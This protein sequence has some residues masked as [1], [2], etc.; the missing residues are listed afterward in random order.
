VTVPD[1]LW[2]SLARLGLALLV[3]ALV[4]LE[5]EDAGKPAGL[6]TLAA[7]SFGSCLF[8]LLAVDLISDWSGFANLR[9]DPIRIV[10]GLIGGI[11]FLGAGA[12]IQ[13]GGSVEG[14][15]TAATIWLTG[16]LGLACGAGSWTLA[17]V[18]TVG[19]LFILRVLG[20]LEKR[21]LDRHLHGSGED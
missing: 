5:R 19:A 21:I 14:I 11:G 15:T 16:A 9:L 4:G 6:R 3:G 7:V 12:I 10:E 20:Y 17:I 1:D 18:G 2:S 13:S 8:T